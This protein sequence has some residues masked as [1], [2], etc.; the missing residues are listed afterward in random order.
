MAQ[1]TDLAIETE[2]KLRVDDLAA[3]AL[4]VVAAGGKLVVPREF[5]D[6]LLLDD[7]AGSLRAAHQLLRLRF[8]PSGM[9]LTFKGAPVP[10]VSFKQREE[11]ETRVSD[12][13]A[14]VEIFGRLGFKVWSRYQKYR[15]E[16]E[17]ALSGVA[18]GT[19]HI[20]LDETP[21]GSFVE[22]EGTD[23]GIRAAASLLGFSESAFIRESYFSLY[24]DYCRRLGRAPAQMVFGPSEHRS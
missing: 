17:L 1:V 2:I 21:I 13:D 12:G 6:N 3:I 19:A 16:Y 9:T 4:K 11:I 22:V 20:A 8:T 23:D 5:E 24:L 10:N 18:G 14:A 15:E 7:G